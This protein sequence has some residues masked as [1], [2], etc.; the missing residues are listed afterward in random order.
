MLK[1]TFR[2]ADGVFMGLAVWAE[3]TDVTPS[4]I[5]DVLLAVFKSE[6]IHGGGSARRVAGDHV[7]TK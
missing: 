2:R 6:A 3:A 5:A 4:R 7:L 1:W